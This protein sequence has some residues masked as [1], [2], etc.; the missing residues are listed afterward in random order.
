MSRIFRQPAVLFCFYCQSSVTPAP[1]NPRVFQCPHCECINHYN[2]RGEIVSDDPAMHD[3]SYNK[4]SFARR[5]SPRKDRLPST[6]GSTSFCH[7]CQ[8][9]QMLLQ[10]LLANYLPPPEDPEYEKRLELLPE[11]QRSIEVRYPPVC[12]NCLPTIEQ[13]IKRKDQMARVRALGSALRN[14][15]GTDNRRRTSATKK[16]REKLDREL[17]I[18]RIRGCLWAASVGCALA[19]HT[20]IAASYHPV[21][22]PGFFSSILLGLVVVS[23]FWTAW[24]PT[25]ATVRRYQFQGR[26]VRVHGKTQYNAL[27]L[28]IWL[29]RLTTAALLALPG[30]RPH[31]DT[32]HLW[33]NPITRPARVYSTTML[34]CEVA[35]LLMCAFVLKVQHPPPVRLV[36]S[37]GHL[38]RLSATPS[39]S[40]SRD[41]TPVVPEPDMFSTLSLSNNPVLGTA[42]AQNPIFGVPS[43]P[44]ASSQLSPPRTG[45]A[46]PSSPGMDMDMDDDGERDPDA[47]DIDP[48]SPAR[49][50]SNNDDGSWLRPQRFFAPEEPTGLETLFAR[51]IRLV[52]PSEQNGRAASVGMGGRKTLPLRR[53]GTLLCDWRLWLSLSI[54]PLFAVGYK[55]WNVYVKN[56][57]IYVIP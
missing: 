9:N 34:V 18:W 44:T 15:R 43:L 25:Y 35:A 30:L 47:M 14:T 23:I 11:Y 10:N 24:D 49:R 45:G 51:T 48:A 54:V 57:V 28:L 16:D 37:N 41:G 50:P 55:A 38:H 21:S 4:R 8:T 56:N 17:W 12:A 20:S 27:Q 36:G 40:S 19:G 33:T 32:I 39:I 13:E 26:A 7:T 42:S 6:H 29:T 3:E 1:R 53:T 46:S 52:D 31:L 22:L 5:A 2:A